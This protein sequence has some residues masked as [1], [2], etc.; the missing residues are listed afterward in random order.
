LNPKIEFIVRC[1]SCKKARI[2]GVWVDLPQT[3]K[4]EVSH[5]I[6]TECVEILYPEYALCAASYNPN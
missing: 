2:D 1:C 4:E 6:C 3:P 5:G